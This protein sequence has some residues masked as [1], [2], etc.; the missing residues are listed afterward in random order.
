MRKV[1]IKLLPFIEYIRYSNL[2][3]M[4]VCGFNTK[5]QFLDINREIGNC[6]YETQDYIINLPV[7]NNYTNKFPNL[8]SC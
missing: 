6:V 1:N 8:F 7:N 3:D 2:K 5:F 4:I